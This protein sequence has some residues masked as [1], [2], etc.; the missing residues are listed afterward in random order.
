MRTERIALIAAVAASV[1]VAVP[2][3]AGTPASGVEAE[4]VETFNRRRS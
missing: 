2:A 1:A 3:R 4:L